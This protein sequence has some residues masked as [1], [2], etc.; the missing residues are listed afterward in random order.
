MNE[1]IL[2]MLS[3]LIPPHD[4]DGERVG[5]WRLAIATTN[6][7]LITGFSAHVALACG[8]IPGFTAFATKSDIEAIQADIESLRGEI[9]SRDEKYVDRDEF[10]T[11][12]ERF[13]A[14]QIAILEDNLIDTRRAQCKAIQSSNTAAKEFAAERMV[15]LQNTYASLTGHRFSS[16]TCEELL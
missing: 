8:L 3:S 1:F 4:A 13:N 6:L 5:R 15:S 7:L 11:F 16:P 14:S 2:R 10:Q 12:L 9:E